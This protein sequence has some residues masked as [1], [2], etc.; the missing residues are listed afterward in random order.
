[1]LPA[2][3][4]ILPDHLPQAQ[5]CSTGRHKRQNVGWTGA[6]TKGQGQSQE[7][8][9]VAAFDGGAGYWEG[10]EESM[11]VDVVFGACGYRLIL[12]ILESFCLSLG[13]PRA[14]K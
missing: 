12:P 10:E 14:G 9:Q 1:M 3:S 13:V 8:I 6:G 11:G 7:G 5:S 2:S 4:L